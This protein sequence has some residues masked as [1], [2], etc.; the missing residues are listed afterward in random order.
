MN[1]NLCIS[2]SFLEF[3]KIHTNIKMLK[4]MQIKRNK[5]NVKRRVQYIDRKYIAVCEN[6]LATLR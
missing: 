4:Y 2:F 3:F 6:T 1:T 5:C